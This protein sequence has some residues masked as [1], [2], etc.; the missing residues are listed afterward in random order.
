[1]TGHDIE[2][3]IDYPAQQHHRKLLSNTRVMHSIGHIIGHAI[4]HL[5]K[6]GIDSA[7][8]H[9][10]RRACKGAEAGYSCGLLK[11]AE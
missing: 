8:A 11:T 5:T 2:H 9:T 1:M 4:D 6:H 10:L 3:D 7:D